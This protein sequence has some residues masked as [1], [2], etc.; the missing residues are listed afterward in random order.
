MCWQGIVGFVVPNVYS[1]GSLL[2]WGRGGG[3]FH[4]NQPQPYLHGWEWE[5]MGFVIKES[6]HPQ[7]GCFDKEL[8]DLR[9]PKI[10]SIDACGER[11]FHPHHPQPA[12]QPQQLPW[13]NPLK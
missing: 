13:A 5:V 12:S 7:L 9:S 11:D 4:S 10:L 1:K 2:L 6:H 8:W 3:D